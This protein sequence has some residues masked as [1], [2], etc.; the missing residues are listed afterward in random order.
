MIVVFSGTGNSRYVSDMMADLLQ[1]EVIDANRYIKER[2]KASLFSEKP[3]IFVSPVYVSAPPKIFMKFLQVSSFKGSTDCYFVQTCAGG[4]GACAYYNQAIAEEKQ[5]EYRGTAEVIMPQN[6]LVYFKTR[7]KEESDRIRKNAEPAIRVLSSLVAEQ[8]NFADPGMTKAEVL[9]TEA[10]L[11]PYYKYFMKAKAF[12]VTDACISCGKCEKVCMFG[13]IRMRDGAPRWGK[14]CMH[15]M[16]CINSCPKEAIEYGKKSVGKP[17]YLC[18]V[19]RTEVNG[20]FAED[21]KNS[22]EEE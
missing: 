9:A 10:I 2:K 8:E 17:R 14:N 22:N 4:M 12:Y 15:C 6:Y 19:Y 7:E 13:N 1:D 18:E 16:A 20:D 5:M 3:W 21:E 11:D